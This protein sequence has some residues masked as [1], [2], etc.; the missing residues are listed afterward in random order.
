M[1]AIVIV[2]VIVIVKVILRVTAIATAKGMAKVS[3]SMQVLEL[4]LS[5]SLC[6]SFVVAAQTALL[7]FAS[8]SRKSNSNDLST[9]CSISLHYTDGD[10]EEINFTVI[11]R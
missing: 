7:A 2:V 11:P 5:K 9:S 1:T 10:E 6:C 4:L 8:L 3:C